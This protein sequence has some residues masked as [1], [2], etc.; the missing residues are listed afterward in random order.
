[1]PVTPPARIHVYDDASRSIK[2]EVRIKVV[3]FP[4]PPIL[5]H[6]IP[7]MSGRATRDR[8][9]NPRNSLLRVR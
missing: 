6:K 1:M 9:Y 8:E 5:I 3:A 7:P 4:E 2:D